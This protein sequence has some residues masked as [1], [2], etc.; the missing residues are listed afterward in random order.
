MAQP[1]YEYHSIDDISLFFCHSTSEVLQKKNSVKKIG[2]IRDD[3]VFA[4]E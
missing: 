3:T 1:C 4:V 2:I